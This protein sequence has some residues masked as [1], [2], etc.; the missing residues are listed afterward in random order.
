M[1]VVAQHYHQQNWKRFSWG[2]WARKTRDLTEMNAAS[3]LMQQRSSCV[4][5]LKYLHSV[6]TLLPSSRQV[7]SKVIYGLVVKFFNIWRVR[8][9]QERQARDFDHHKI[10]REAWAAWNDKIRCQTLQ[11][12]I[13]D[14]IVL[15]ALYKWVLAERLILARRLLNRKTVRA[16]LERM[17]LISTDAFETVSAGSLIALKFWE[18]NS[19][20]ISLHRWNSNLNTHKYLHRFATQR[21]ATPIQTVSLKTWLQNINHMRQLQAWAV[22]ADFYFV[23]T[24]TLKIWRD[25]AEASRKEKR[26]LA[27][28][29][30]RRQNKL[31]L[32]SALF[33]TWRH[34]SKTVIQ[35][36]NRASEFRCNRVY[37]YN[38][39]TLDRWRARKEE[40]LQLHSIQLSAILKVRYAQWKSSSIEYYRSDVVACEFYENHLNI[41]CMK[42]WGFLAL[43]FRAH[44]HLVSELHD[45]HARR[46]VRKMI[47]HWR[48]QLF[49]YEGPEP[50]NL[51]R[52]STVIKQNS[53]DRIGTVEKAGVYAD[54]QDD[55]NHSYLAHR[56]GAFLNPTP[57]RGYLRTPSKR[58]TIARA[59]NQ[60]STTPVA[61]LSTPY[62]RQ[63]RAQFSGRLLRPYS[64]ASN[65]NSPSTEEGFDD[66][67][68]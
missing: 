43:Q 20:W 64:R 13:G 53:S 68:G 14:R 26:R 23:A 6:H 35:M 62:E 8:T 4:N 34:Q 28:A 12:R 17:Q 33:H 5:A 25:V 45:K 50:A 30:V 16:S 41:A 9:L 19:K 67:R 3:T 55:T 42:K 38:I 65:N 61:P 54:L 49:N 18:H 27:Y 36:R 15:Q 51:A 66:L 22:D 24:K 47:L 11:L 29:S 32:A 37:S 48:Q 10:K 2:I 57:G 44:Q 1:S 63:L 60:S 21:S 7:E 56:N 39:Y 52:M 40:V 59:V 31:K 58:I 46:A